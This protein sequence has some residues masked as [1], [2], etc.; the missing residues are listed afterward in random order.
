MKKYLVF[1]WMM[2]A[3]TIVLWILF[4]GILLRNHWRALILREGYE[5]GFM[6]GA[7]HYKCVGNFGTQAFRDE[8]WNMINAEE[9]PCQ[10]YINKEL[11]ILKRPFQEAR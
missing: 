11:E 8:M 5:R 6:Q 9:L 4:V 2:R 1:A 3:A 7:L 10:F